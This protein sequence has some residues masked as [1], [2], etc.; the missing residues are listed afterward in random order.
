MSGARVIA[1]PSWYFPPGINR[2]EACAALFPAHTNHMMPGHGPDVDTDKGAPGGGV[3]YG[4][5]YVKGQKG[6]QLTDDG[7]WINWTKSE[8]QHFT[9][10]DTHPRVL[11]WD[12]IEGSHPGHEWLIPILLTC[13]KTKRGKFVFGSALEA[14]LGRSGWG[15]CEDLSDLQMRMFKVAHGLRP[16]T[17]ASTDELVTLVYDIICLGHQGMTLNDLK[18]V[19]WISARFLIRVLLTAAGFPQEPDRG[20]PA[21]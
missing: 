10:M 3:V 11:R 9:R 12:T 13:A 6:W 16:I 2:T 14:V 15:D 7:Y 18:A 20:D 17:P 21:Q 19:G 5:G 1:V 4:G 8:P